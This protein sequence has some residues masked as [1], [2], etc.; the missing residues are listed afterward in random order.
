MLPKQAESALVMI[1]GRRIGRL[2]PHCESASTASQSSIIPGEPGALLSNRALSF[3]L[4]AA[5]LT[6]D[7]NLRE[8]LS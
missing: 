8:F 7:L 2:D 1:V 4:E 3:R 5:N 6:S